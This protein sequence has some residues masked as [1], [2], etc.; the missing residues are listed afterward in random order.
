MF[1]FCEKILPPSKIRRSGKAPSPS[2]VTL[3]NICLSRSNLRTSVTRRRA[4]GNSPTF[5]EFLSNATSLPV[6]V[7][8]LSERVVVFLGMRRYF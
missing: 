8:R 3:L 5:P 1:L 2:L 4:R 6:A 7:A